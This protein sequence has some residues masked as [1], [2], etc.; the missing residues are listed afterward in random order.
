MDA[1]HLHLM[2]NHIPILGTIIVALLL[3][4]GLLKRSRELMR[5]ALGAA[6]IVALLSYPVFLTGGRAEDQVGDLP[7]ATERLIENHE[8][9]AEIAL[10]A[11][12]A[13][14]VLAAAALWL[15]R[16]GRPV[17]KIA[18]GGVVAALALSA[19]LCGWAALSGGVIRH[20]EIRS[21][22]T[23]AAT[24]GEQEAASPGKSD[25]D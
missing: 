21:G 18:S 15:S 6:V 14:G 9:Q 1:A 4:W 5:T 19:G 16:G 13:T 17:P 7:W 10:V 24:A 23:A 20:D 8:E 2:V 3:G 11:M 25:D 22:A 12:L